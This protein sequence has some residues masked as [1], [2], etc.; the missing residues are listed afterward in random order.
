MVIKE[1]DSELLFHGKD[2]EKDSEVMNEA[3]NDS[4]LLTNEKADE[5]GN[6]NGYM[7][8]NSKNDIKETIQMPSNAEL[9]SF[10]AKLKKTIDCPICTETLQRPFTTSCGHTYCYECLKSWLKESKSCPTCRQKIHTQPSPAYLVYDLMGVIASV[11]PTLSLLKIR[12]DPSKRQEEVLFDGIFQG[13]EPLYP[14]GILQDAED[15]VLR[16][17]RCH[18]ELEN[19]YH[20]DHCGFQISDEADSDREWF[21]DNEDLESGGSE[22]ETRRRANLSR[23]PP[24]TAVP[25]DWI[26]FGEEAESD[27]S[28]AGDYDLDDEFID[29]RNASQLSPIE[30]NEDDFIVPDEEVDEPNLAS[31]VERSGSDGEASNQDI[32]TEEL[33]NRKN[34]ELARELYDLYDESSDYQRHGY[35]TEGDR[36]LKRS[37][38]SRP[39]STSM[40]IDD[41]EED[42]DDEE[43]PQFG[44]HLNAALERNE[45]R[46]D[47]DEDVT[48]SFSSYAA[49]AA[50][51][52]KPSR[53]TRTIH[54]DSED[55]EE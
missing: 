43:M 16:C 26:G 36:P 53:R 37:R 30:N 14:T 50:P 31:Q 46:F 44:P 6:E 39:R 13:T 41:D 3:V 11:D 23:R 45:N 10:L 20:C 47:V 18:W 24:I 21:W 5:E 55:E 12:D 48:D 49:S 51:S 42:V 8:F 22:E 40:L 52:R 17:A 28:G 9:P 7:D 2:V 1:S 32:D 19:P 4:T 54:V 38:H 34:E 15:G 33:E 27:F 29:N 25:E 35:S